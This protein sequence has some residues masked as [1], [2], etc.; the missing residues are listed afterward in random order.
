MQATFSKE[1]SNEIKQRLYKRGETLKS[2]CLAN[3]FKYYTAS[4]VLR[5]INKANYGEGREVALRLNQL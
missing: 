2:W 4:N 1:H 5:G 3:N